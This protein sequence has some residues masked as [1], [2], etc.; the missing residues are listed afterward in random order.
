MR[1]GVW[2]RVNVRSC[3]EG[4]SQCRPGSK[5]M[6][7]WEWRSLAFWAH[8][9]MIGTSTLQN[10]PGPCSRHGWL[11]PPLSQCCPGELFMFP[12]SSNC[13]RYQHV[14]AAHR[15]ACSLG[16]TQSQRMGNAEYE[17]IRYWLFIN[18]N[19]NQF[20]QNFSFLS[21]IPRDSVHVWQSWNFNELKEND[22]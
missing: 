15:W 11:L 17:C 16:F 6:I 2:K 14:W 13:H 10:A 1:K 22:C 19:W 8:L 3:L 20:A 21:F 12:R 18:E 9:H 5:A 7:H 4:L